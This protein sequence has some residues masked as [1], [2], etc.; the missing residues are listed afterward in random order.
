MSVD[1]STLESFS[2]KQVILHHIQD[3]GTVAEREGK[4]DG[5]SEAGMA[6]KEKGR[7]DVEL[8]LPNQIEELSLA[9]TKPKKLSQKKLKLVTESNVRQHLLDRHALTRAAVNE[10][11][12]EEGLAVHEA[13][14]HSDLGH[15]HVAEDEAKESDE[16]GDSEE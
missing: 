7:R 5:A 6:F 10:M 2:G 16:S 9:P 8:I 14:D 1:A 11:S 12:D 15:R 4:V 13:I 3:D